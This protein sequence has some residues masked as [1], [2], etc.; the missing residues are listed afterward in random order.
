MFTIDGLLRMRCGE[1]KGRVRN[2]CTYLVAVGGGTVT[3]NSLAYEA[4]LPDD[5]SGCSCRPSE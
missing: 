5:A 4:S 3:D 1:G 2:I